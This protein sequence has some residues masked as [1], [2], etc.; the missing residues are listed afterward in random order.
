MLEEFGAAHDVVDVA[1]LLGRGRIEQAGAVLVAEFVLVD[2]AVVDDLLHEVVVFPVDAGEPLLTRFG[3]HRVEGIAE[4]L[5]GSG[6]EVLLGDLLGSDACLEQGV[7]DGS[8]VGVLLERAGDDADGTDEGTVVGDDFVGGGGRVDTARG[9]HAGDVHEH[10][11]A[12]ALL[13][14]RD[15]IGHGLRSGDR[16]AGG[17]HEQQ[18]AGR[19]VLGEFVDL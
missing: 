17:V 3:V 1:V 4:G 15:R 19:V 14:A 7:A 11:L 8:H 5:A 9:G 10:R 6:G 2:R 18:E 16:A 13:V 12:G